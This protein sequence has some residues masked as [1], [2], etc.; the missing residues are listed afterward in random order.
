[1]C[2]EWH[3]HGIPLPEFLFCPD[4][5]LSALCTIRFCLSS[6]D[7]VQLHNIESQNRGDQPSFT[8]CEAL[9]RCILRDCKASPFPSIIS[10]ASGYDGFCFSV[11]LNARQS[12][13]HLRNSEFPAVCSKVT[14]FTSTKV[15]RCT[16]ARRCSARMMK[17]SIGYARIIQMTVLMTSGMI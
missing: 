10:R 6:N 2:R 8:L 1:M 7:R 11:F 3:K 14:S 9:N 12:L 5:D 13:C 17:S 15:H 4:N 16:A